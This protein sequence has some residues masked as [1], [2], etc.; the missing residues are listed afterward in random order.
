MT[1]KYITI[2]NKN[3]KALFEIS[4][5]IEENKKLKKINELLLKNSYE[6]VILSDQEKKL[7]KNIETYIDNDNKEQAIVICGY[8][9]NHEYFNYKSSYFH[10]FDKP[11]YNCFI[12]P[13]YLQT[14]YLLN[15]AEKNNII[16]YMIPSYVLSNKHTNKI[17]RCDSYEQYKIE[18]TPHLK[19]S[20][21]FK[22]PFISHLLIEFKPLNFAILNSD[23][24]P[25]SFVKN[26]KLNMKYGRFLFYKPKNLILSD[27]NDIT[28]LFNIDEQLNL[29][30][31]IA[32]PNKKS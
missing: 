11:T 13:S 29:Y 27:G 16:V 8:K 19:S 21:L 25:E 4:E 12:D 22:Y 15:I 9:Y 28:E 3:I 6:N 30:K 2:F 24:Y 23:T 32:L 10:F 1:D 14:Q 5:L 7:Q 20:L 26:T 18:F 31:F 17:R